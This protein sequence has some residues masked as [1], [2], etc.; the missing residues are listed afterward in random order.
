MR[1]QR[2]GLQQ[3]LQRIA[4]K[5]ATGIVNIRFQLTDTVTDK[6]STIYRVFF[7]AASSI[8]SARKMLG[9]S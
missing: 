2:P 3:T 6:T 9:R 1:I 8:K 4:Q 5:L 7:C